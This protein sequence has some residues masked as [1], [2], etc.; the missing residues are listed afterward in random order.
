MADAQPLSPQPLSI[1]I[2]ALGGE[3]GGVLTDWIVAA[4]EA[5]GFPIQSTSIPGVAQR[6]GATTYFI[7]LLPVPRGELG[8]RKPVLALYPSPGHVD[9]AIASEL[10][11]AGR[12]LETALVTPDRT[13]LVASTHRIYSIAEKSAMGDGRF[14]TAK[15][16]KAANELARRAVLCDLAAIARREGTV[17][18]AV[19][20]G[21][22]AGSGALPFATEDFERAIRDKK[23]AVDSNLRGFAAGVAIGRGELPTEAPATTPTQGAPVDERV[24]TRFPAVLHEIVGHGVARLTDYQD[25]AYAAR[26]LDRLAPIVAAEGAGDL[27]VSRETARYLALWMSYEDVIRVADL[28]TR[29]ARLARVRR[30]VGAAGDQ[31]VQVAEFLKPGLEEVASVLPPALG[32]AVMRWSE[33]GDRLKRFHVGLNLRTDTVSGFVRLRAVA[34]LKRWRPRTFR[35]AEEQA[36]IEDWLGLITAALDR[37]RALALEIAETARVLKGY[38]DTARRGRHNY[39]AIMDRLVRPALSGAPVLDIAEAVR[40]ARATALANPDGPQLDAMLER[41][42]ARPSLLQAA[43]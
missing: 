41:R 1:V 9:V 35:F 33:R 10:I 39:A 24:R 29:A 17:L 18:N 31:P 3:G 2:A 6:T 25:T 19:V 30:E 7:E 11:E 23:V 14:D 40:A 21:V 13:L 27:A 37:D 4:A 22:I 16:L 42:R 15:V 43:Q 34:A 5:R 36:A 32:R 20:L 38:S 26:Y 12:L 28:K 8:G